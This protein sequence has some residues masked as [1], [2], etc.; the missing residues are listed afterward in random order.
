MATPGLSYAQTSTPGLSGTNLRITAT[1]P[2]L[3]VNAGVASGGLVI[4][5]YTPP[6]GSG[7]G[8]GGGGGGT[9]PVDH[10]FDAWGG[11]AGWQQANNQIDSGMS[12]IR[13]NGAGAFQGTYD[14]LHQTYLNNARGAFDTQQGI[15][16]SRSN[17]E[18]NRLNGIQ[19]VLGYV[20][21]GLKQGGARLAAANATDSSATGALA[22][23]YQQVGAGKTRGLNNQAA[24]KTNEIDNQQA[25]L[26]RGIERQKE[27]LGTAKNNEA[28]RIGR[29]VQ[30][31]LTALDRQAQGLSLPGRVAIDQEKQNIINAGM[32]Q[33]N[34]LDGFFQG[35][36]NKIH[37]QT[38]DETSQQA[39]QLQLAGTASSNPFTVQPFEQQQVQG[40]PIDQLPLFT[41]FGRNKDTQ[42]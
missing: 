5:G 12:D 22:R 27:D 32:A 15:N 28:A 20:R 17:N 26:Q 38:S 35:E 42:V 36:L 30:N 24:I 14:S 8:G 6:S 2:E 39:R 1:K 7:G 37:Q 13:N 41:S 16:T 10:T 9:S 31:Q 33:L 4:D 18:L 23:A 11:Q 3:N 25:T 40:A 19:D 29:D 21:S 34:Q